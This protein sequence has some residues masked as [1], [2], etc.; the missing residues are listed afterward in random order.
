[1][2]AT[3]DFFAGLGCLV[4]ALV[5]ADGNIDD[6]ELKS[7]GHAMLEGFGDWVMS[8]TGQRALASFEMM[9]S[10]GKTPE[11]AYKEAMRYFLLDKH[12]LRRFRDKIL[13]VLKDVAASDEKIDETELDI[14]ERFERETLDL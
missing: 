11:E 9:N 3:R 12:E 2:Q 10:A 13:E 1:M 7:Y 14:L 4:Y 5:K 8:S 6:S